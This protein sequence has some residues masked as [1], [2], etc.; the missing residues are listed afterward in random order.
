M[1][2]T[3]VLRLLRES[4]SAGNIDQFV[5]ELYT[6]F[7]QTTPS[8]SQ[9]QLIL[10]QT[11]NKPVLV[12]QNQS[13]DGN[14]VIQFLDGQGNDV[15][16]I[17]IGGATKTKGQGGITIGTVDQGPGSVGKSDLTG[18][19]YA[20]TPPPLAAGGQ[21]SKGPPVIDFTLGPGATLVATGNPAAPTPVGC[22]PCQVQTGTGTT[23]V[24]LVYA[25]GIS[26]AP[27]R[28]AV[29][30]LENAGQVQA[31]TWTLCSLGPDGRYTMQAD[32]HL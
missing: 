18:V 14:R 5:E 23:Y 16:G 30:Q 21:N 20:S 15:G 12:I 13:G 6:L 4:W 10:T 1:I 31:G 7:Q 28:T 22:F 27:I 3:Q 32:T 24:C 2:P 17:T 11:N 26:G 29:Q 9:G 8:G 19:K 25:N